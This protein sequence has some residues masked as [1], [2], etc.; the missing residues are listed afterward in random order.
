MKIVEFTRDGNI[1]HR[2]DLFDILDPFRLG[3]D[4]LGGYWRKKGFAES[5]DWSHANAI[6]YLADDDSFTIFGFGIRMR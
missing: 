5:A 3:Y 4:S 1:V 6:D 2:W